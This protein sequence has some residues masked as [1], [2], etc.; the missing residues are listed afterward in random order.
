MLWNFSGVSSD[1]SPGTILHQDPYSFSLS[2]RIRAGPY[3]YRLTRFKLI[4][5]KRG[6]RP[7]PAYEVCMSAIPRYIRSTLLKSS[8]RYVWR[9]NCRI[10]SHNYIALLENSQQRAGIDSGNIVLKH[11]HHST[12]VC[13]CRNLQ[14][15]PRQCTYLVGLSMPNQEYIH[16]GSITFWTMQLEW[17]CEIVHQRH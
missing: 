13:P 6:K 16:N 12:V 11:M 15:I 9:P 5:T 2:P 14:R 17:R 1:S 8:L 4:Y 3:W 7:N 10:I